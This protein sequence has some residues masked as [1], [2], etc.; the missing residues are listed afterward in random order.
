MIRVF[1]KVSLIAAFETAVPLL[2]ELV[3][4]VPLRVFF[5]EP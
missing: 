5:E 3:V 4:L 1:Q 2:A